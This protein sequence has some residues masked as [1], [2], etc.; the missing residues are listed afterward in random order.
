MSNPSAEKNLPRG[1]SSEEAAEKLKRFGRNE[2]SSQ[3]ES[4]WK[5]ILS[6]VTEPMLSLLIL[7]GIL[8]AVLGNLEEAA[9]LSIAV[10]AVISITIYQNNKSK[11]ALASLKELAPLKARAVRDGRITIIP[12]GEVVPDD[13]IVLQEGD[14]VSADGFLTF[15]LNLNVDES[16][17]TGESVSIPKESVF[18]SDENMQIPASS[19]SLVFAGSTVVA[20]EGV[21]RVTATGDSTEIGKIGK[22]L[23]N[24]TQSESP[25][26]SE[27]KR[28]TIFFTMFAGILCVFLIVGLGL[29]HGRWL[30]AI[31][32]G[33]TFSMAVLPEEIPVVLSVFFSLGAWRISKIGVLTKNLSAIETLGA[34][35]VLCVDK[36]GTLTENNMK[37]RG[38]YCEGEHLECNSKL[39]EIPEKFHSLLEF[40]LLAS[41]KDPYDPMEKAI[42]DLGITFLSGTE[43][44][45][46]DWELKK[47][48]PLSP[49]LMALSYAWLSRE[50]DDVLF[51]GAKGAP[52][53]IF[54]L[55]HFSEE[56]LNEW[57]N[58]V[59]RYSS[60]GFRI[61]GVAKSKSKTR[62]IPEDQH[63][64]SFDFLGLI[65][66]EDPIRES[67][68]ASV[69]E[70]KRAGIK[71]VMIT[72]DHAGTAK[73]IADQIGFDRSET[74]ISGDELETLSDDE[75]VSRLD[76]VRIF[77]RIRPHQKLKIIRCFQSKGETVAMTGDG[78]NDTL[79]LHAAHIG[80]SMGKRGTDVAREA[81]D[82]VLL[83]DNFSSIVKAVMLGR[84]IYEN[85]QKSVS[86]I[87][88][89]HIPIIGM[90]LL[91]VLTGDP[92]YFFPAH[93]LLLELIIDPACTLVFEGVDAEKHIYA[94]PPRRGKD[95]L[96]SF[97]NASM[98]LLRGGL[99]LLVLIALSFWGKHENWTFEKIRSMAF[100]CLVS[101]N[102]GMILIHLSKDV[103]FYR[104]LTRS[105]SILYWIS[106]LTILI[107]TFIFHVDLLTRLFGFVMISWFDVFS[108]V[109][110]GL[111]VSL[112]WEVKK[113]KDNS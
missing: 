85:I 77:C 72:G 90:S 76:H 84:R 68:P 24:I 59:E 40:A 51:I 96:M 47:E 17:L 102:L 74:V 39:S 87:I 52:E 55:C 32:A 73:S 69:L 2:L 67:V 46:F 57:G 91:P 82:L 18:E 13:V 88:S 9:M 49:K 78:V 106:G 3:R 108:S 70:C 30:E 45:H 15:S 23:K 62:G 113:I 61:L 28:F 94:S 54:D 22:E 1:H 104:V 56:L 64:L 44:I 110:I 75:L 14:R 11:N 53:A 33:L 35:T 112:L 107:L 80:I 89:V 26:Q 105:N 19:K 98:S 111:A 41:K 37:V 109:A 99:I 58:I 97:Q 50:N 4:F 43:H 31:L 12:S 101:S 95:S 27:I 6:V 10:I 42:R 7:C 63:D 81:S 34:A 92:L 38:L 100:L 103:P 29:R 20:G 36:T 60:Q 86:Y 79:A 48:Y 16:L 5:V 93:V 8:Y 83:D 25:L 66:L 71:V 21:F 65:L